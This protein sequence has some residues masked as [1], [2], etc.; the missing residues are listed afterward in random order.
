MLATESHALEYPF[1]PGNPIVGDGNGIC[2]LG[3]AGFVCVSASGAGMTALCSG[4]GFVSGSGGM[5]SIYLTLP[6][7]AE[8]PSGKTRLGLWIGFCSHGK[9]V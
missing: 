3:L 2:K 1:E 7:G 8:S 4:A 9:T 5:S 6:G